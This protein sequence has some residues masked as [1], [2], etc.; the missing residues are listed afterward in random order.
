MIGIDSSTSDVLNVTIH[1]V[2]YI[3]IGGWTLLATFH[4]LGI[5]YGYVDS[6][7]IRTSSSKTKRMFRS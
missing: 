3:L 1:V 5:S 7:Q 6:F 4:I 2:C